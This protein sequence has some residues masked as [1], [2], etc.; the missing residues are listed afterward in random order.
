MRS[1]TSAQSWRVASWTPLCSQSWT[2][3]TRSL[4][5]TRGRVVG[6]AIRA[7]TCVTPT[8]TT[9]GTAQHSAPSCTTQ[10]KAAAGVAAV[11]IETTALDLPLH[12]TTGTQTLSNTAKASTAHSSTATRNQGV[13]VEGSTVGVESS[14]VGV[15][16]SKVGV[17][18]PA[19]TTE[20]VAP[21]TA[22]TPALEVAMVE[23]LHPQLVVTQPTAPP[24]IAVVHHPQ[25]TVDTA[26][27]L[28]QGA[29]A[30]AT[31]RNRNLQGMAAL[32]QPLGTAR[33]LATAEVLPYTLQCVLL[34]QVVLGT[35][36]PQHQAMGLLL[37]QEDTVPLAVMAVPLPLE[38]TGRW[39]QVHILPPSTVPPLRRMAPR[40]TVQPPQLMERPPRQATTHTQRYS[41]SSNN[42]STAG[43][44]ERFRSDVEW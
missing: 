17:E 42:S 37:R 38:D 40:P 6:G 23:A 1:I 30:E 24:R 2:S 35:V 3:L 44:V 33:P 34:L 13:V 29:M 8:P 16:S 41:A 4:C 25:R 19:G 11:T 21:H 32:Q 5:G 7:M 9:T 15:E 36:P 12:S 18:I 14:T 26:P 31:G 20:V 28:L 39:C 22:A 27:P 10:A 43:S